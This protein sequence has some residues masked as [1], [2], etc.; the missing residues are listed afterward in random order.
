MSA[1]L[2]T[3]D[4]VL[5]AHNEAD[6]IEAVLIEFH[7]M[8]SRAGLEVRLVVC[9]DG[10]SDGT[11]DVV[12]RLEARLPVR[13]LSSPERKGYSRAVVDGLLA[14]TADVVGCA[15]SDGQCHPGDLARMAAALDATTDLVVGYRTRRADSLVR[16]AMSKAFGFAY[17]VTFPVRLRDPSSPY[18]L[19]RRSAL[20][21][22][23]QG[24]PGVLRQGFWW[25]FY[26]R[27]HAAGLR[28]R[29]VPTTHR[30]RLAGST[31]VY[32]PSRVPRIA[33]EHLLGLRSL[34]R[35]LAHVRRG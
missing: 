21:A 26:A 33:W 8:T 22:A 32:R 31:V 14:T 24:N 34:K 11:A 12:R 28:I 7:E 5:P 2:G 15:D 27:A 30:P 25:E 19:I 13:L 10:S 9:E 20:L 35:E 16:R 4:I 6:T 17:R 1:G 23:L 29:E 18:L 3:I